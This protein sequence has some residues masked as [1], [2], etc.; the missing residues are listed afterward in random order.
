[1]TEE[2]AERWREEGIAVNAMHPGWADTPGVET[3]LPGFY[4]ATRRLLRTPA[5]GADTIVWLAASTEA[6]KVS[7]EFWLDREQHPSHIMRR[8]RETPEERAT[9]VETLQELAQSSRPVRRQRQASGKR[10]A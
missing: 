2:W 9:L 5:E 10:S 8:T 7:G 1:M 4:R 3:S 6:G